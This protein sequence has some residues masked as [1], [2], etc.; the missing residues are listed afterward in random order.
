MVVKYFTFVGTK[1]YK[2][3]NVSSNRMLMKTIKESFSCK[4]A[5]IKCIEYNATKK[6]HS[7]YKVSYQNI[8]LTIMM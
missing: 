4:V 3:Q 8:E 6:F 2:T 5:K 1:T 7:Y